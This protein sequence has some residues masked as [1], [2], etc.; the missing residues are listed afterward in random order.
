M[1][2]LRLLVCALGEPFFKWEILQARR[3]IL[4]I[5]NS[6]SMRATDV[7][8]TRLDAAKQLGRQIVSGLRFR[9]EMAII[10]AG[11]QPQVVCGLTGHERP[12]Q[13]ALAGVKPTD[14]PTREPAAIELGHRLLAD[15]NHGPVLPLSDGCFPES[16][17]LADD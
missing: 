5:D 4:V 7:V 10:A 9:D 6:A 14:G 3:L 16:E 17:N 13:A 15:A 12:L 8:P 2:W 1:A 11:V